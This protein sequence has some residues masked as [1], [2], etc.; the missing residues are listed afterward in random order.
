MKETMRALNLHAVG[1]LRL[2]TLPLPTC[3][4][5][6]VL[7]RIAYC[8]VCGSDIP[9]VFDKGT[10]HFPT[11]IGH[12]F[13]GTVAYDPR[14]E[15]EG[16]RVAVFP[17]L[18]CFSCESC[19][20]EQY[21]LCSDYDYYGSR[22]DGGMA[23]YLAVKRW[24]L[25]PL[26]ENVS[27]A[28]GAMCE[29]SAVACHAVRKLGELAGKRLLIS[30]AGP[31]GLLAAMWAKDKGAEQV[32]F[33][34]L[35]ERKLRAAEAMGFAEYRDGDA[36]DVCIEGTGAG[37]ALVRCLKA[38]KP[39]GRI[40]LMGNPSRGIELTQQDYWLILRKEL[41]LLGTWNSSFGE[42]QNDWRDAIR[43]MSEGIITP[44]RL[45]THRVAM[46]D[47]QSA[48]ALMRDRTEFYQKVMLEVEAK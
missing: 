32:Y 3:G 8:G 44:E 23:E 12:E 24:N 7:V 31:I 45:I 6:E 47:Y 21:A 26:P 19:R 22:R 42:A 48:F 1:D 38:L 17:L 41:R 18:P 40:V 30:G 34:D 11:V 16:T 15:L 39:F 37:A 43:A 29:P 5:D 20:Q 27:L 36:V 46:E 9:R 35:D 28:A 13:S 2:D 4:E 25:L 14:G 33:F 10:Y